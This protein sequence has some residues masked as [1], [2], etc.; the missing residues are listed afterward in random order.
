MDSTSS[1]LW[2]L[3]FGSI[4]MGYFIYGKKQKRGV[5]FASGIGL[6]VFPYFVSNSYL[7]VIIGVALLAVPYFLRY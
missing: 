3:I 1:L 7:M 5:P 2:G 4:G 6:M